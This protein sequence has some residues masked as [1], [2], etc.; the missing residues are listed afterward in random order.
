M[1]VS[2]G[3]EGK[4]QGSGQTDSQGFS[5]QK[6]LEMKLA[7]QAKDKLSTADGHRRQR[8]ASDT[9]DESPGNAKSYFR[10]LRTPLERISERI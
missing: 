3:S 7:L 5:M 1:S 9:T 8:A 10:G 6:S 4:V 2:S